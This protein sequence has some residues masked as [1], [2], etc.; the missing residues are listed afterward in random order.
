MTVRTTASFQE[1]W[2]INQ[3]DRALSVSDKTTK[4]FIVKFYTELTEDSNKWDKRKAFEKA[5]A[6]IRNNN[7]YRDPYYWPGFVMLD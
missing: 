1:S 6:Y 7:G 4:A 2:S 5:R 3:F